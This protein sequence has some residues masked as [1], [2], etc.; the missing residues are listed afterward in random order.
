MLVRSPAIS[1]DIDKDWVRK[2]AFNGND[3]TQDECRVV[4]FL[5]N[6]LRPYVPRLQRT[7]GGGTEE[8]AISVAL[9]APIVI[10]SNAVMRITGYS[11]FCRRICPAISAAAIHALP[12]SATNLYET[13]CSKWPNQFDV[14]GPTGDTI[15]QVRS[16]TELPGYKEAMFSGFFNMETI[17]NY[18]QNHNLEF[19][20]R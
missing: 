2:S 9:G 15:T 19:A 14:I 17:R 11:Q 6:L 3:L 18:C 4:A 16:I 12:L 10:I 8:P 13:F 1:R 7:D 5:A 20:N